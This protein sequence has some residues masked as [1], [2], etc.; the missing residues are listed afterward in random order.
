MRDHNEGTGDRD[1]FLAFKPESS[2]TMT[3]NYGRCSISDI[4]S[5]YGALAAV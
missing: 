3:D 1:S 2:M 4:V 5:G